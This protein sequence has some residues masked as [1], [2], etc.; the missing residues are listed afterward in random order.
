M[1]VINGIRP[2]IINAT[3]LV[4]TNGHKVV[5]RVDASDQEECRAQSRPKWVAPYF[6]AYVSLQHEQTNRWVWNCHSGGK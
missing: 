4:L 2:A 1:M 6:Y 3:H 5:G